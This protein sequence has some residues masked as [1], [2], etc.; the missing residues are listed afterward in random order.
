MYMNVVHR[1]VTSF[2]C[3]I[4]TV[5]FVVLALSFLYLDGNLFLCIAQY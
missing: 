3:H 2:T 1:R 4:F 5:V